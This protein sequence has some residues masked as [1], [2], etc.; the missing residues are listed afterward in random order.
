MISKGYSKQRPRWSNTNHSFLKKMPTSK[1]RDPHTSLS[2][3][4]VV[5]WI[6]ENLHKRAMLGVLDDL[7]IKSW[8]KKRVGS[9]C[10][11]FGLKPQST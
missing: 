3:R 6:R 2:S 10:G 5:L 8:P 4:L 1:P 9:R 11:L 7:K